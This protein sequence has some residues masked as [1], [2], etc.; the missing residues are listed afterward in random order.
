MS[1]NNSERVGGQFNACPLL[2]R[3]QNFQRIVG[4]A[5][6]TVNAFGKSGSTVA[7][8]AELL[9]EPPARIGSSYLIN[10]M[11]ERDAQIGTVPLP[12]VELHATIDSFGKF[13]VAD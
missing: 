12:D 13:P 7:D 9:S 1:R 8:A 11:M 3:S 10:N 2:L 4:E 6:F 5:F